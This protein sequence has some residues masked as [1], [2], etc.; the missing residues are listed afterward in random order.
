MQ[1]INYKKISYILPEIS[2]LSG[3][4]AFEFLKNII[5]LK[6]VLKFTFY[7]H[8][9]KNE[10]LGLIREMYGNVVILPSK[11]N[12]EVFL[13]NNFYIHAGLLKVLCS[14]GK[15]PNFLKISKIDSNLKTDQID[16][17]WCIEYS[18]EIITFIYADKFI[19]NSKIIS[20]EHEFLSKG[21]VY[22]RKATKD[23][24]LK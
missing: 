20:I 13:I 11:D 9:I 5:T 2:G 4:I 12:E 18:D 24:R 7:G 14:L 3:Q 1:Y 6:D 10:S 22:E 17:C 23:I 8:G 19:D 16:Y 21:I 15:F